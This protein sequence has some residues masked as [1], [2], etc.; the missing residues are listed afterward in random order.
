VSQAILQWLTD[1]C[2]E[3]AI[4]DPVVGAI[5]PETNGLKN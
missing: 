4:I 3:T 2:I 1:A 5:F